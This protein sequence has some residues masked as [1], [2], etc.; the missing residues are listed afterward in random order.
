[1]AILYSIS[2]IIIKLIKWM[3]NGFS[4]LF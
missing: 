1:M 2:S 4:K 3:L